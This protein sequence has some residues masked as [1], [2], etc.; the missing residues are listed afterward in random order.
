MGKKGLLQTILD[1]SIVGDIKRQSESIDEER[2]SNRLA[3]EIAKEKLRQSQLENVPLSESIVTPQVKS[4][5]GR[6]QGQDIPLSE[7]I[8]G[9]LETR[10]KGIEEARQTALKGQE[11]FGTMTPSQFKEFKTAQS[12]DQNIL[13][14]IPVQSLSPLAKEKALKA[15]FADTV[16]LSA[17]NFFE[18]LSKR[19]TPSKLKLSDLQRERDSILKKS[20]F[21]RTEEEE[22]KLNLLNEEI[23]STLKLDKPQSK[24]LPKEIEKVIVRDK[25]GKQFRLP[26][27]QLEA[28]KKQGYTLATP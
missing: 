18:N 19:E 21:E 25:N 23:E 4:I 6:V 7:L 3:I 24:P 10:E 12:F 5:L 8:S 14:K 26:K 2:E 11:E 15:G 17:A 9:Q 1:A 16:S 22:N 13:R 27:T 20:V 28:A